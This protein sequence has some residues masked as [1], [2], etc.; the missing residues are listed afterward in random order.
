MEGHHH[1]TSSS[2]NLALGDPS[3]ATSSAE[4]NFRDGTGSS[5]CSR[6]EDGVEIMLDLEVSEPFCRWNRQRN[7]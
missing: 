6:L 3:V 4:G 1:V 7:R 2:E 5:D